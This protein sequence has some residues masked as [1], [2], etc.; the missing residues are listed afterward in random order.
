MRTLSAP[1]ATRLAGSEGAT[2][3]VFWSPDGRDIGFVANGRLKRIAATGGPV[4]SLTAIT[5][6]NL[7]ATWNRDGVIVFA[8]ETGELEIYV[9]PVGR[10]GRTGSRRPAAAARAGAPTAASCSIS[11]RQAT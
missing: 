9:S 5:G 10:P 7:G 1:T 8:L 4:T 6:G 2:G 3:E 11:R